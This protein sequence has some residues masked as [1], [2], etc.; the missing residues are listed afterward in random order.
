MAILHPSAAHD[1]ALG[2][3][4]VAF[5]SSH[6]L[7]LSAYHPNGPA[8]TIPPEITL[9]AGSAK[10]DDET[11]PAN[12]ALDTLRRSGHLL[13]LRS[14][15]EDPIPEQRCGVT[16]F[17]DGDRS[18]QAGVYYRNASGDLMCRYV[19]IGTGVTNAMK[20]I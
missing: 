6:R 7:F 2:V 1:H 20:L 12:P 14:D 16:I 8:G 5:W 4:Y 13:V 9:V 19:T 17:Q 15:S 18:S 11:N 3:T 10:L